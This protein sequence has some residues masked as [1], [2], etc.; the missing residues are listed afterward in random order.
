[1][2]RRAN[3][4]LPTWPIEV[5]KQQVQLLK[6]LAAPPFPVFEGAPVTVPTAQ[7]TGSPVAPGNRIPP[8]GPAERERYRNMFLN[9]GAQNGLLDGEQARTIF[10]R[11][12]LP[13]ET[14]GQIWYDT[15]P[16]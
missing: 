5:D 7:A 10:L 16:A 9:T 4:P 12:R 3:I 6:V 14:L 8:L 15:P 2:L 13:N 11:A 1:M